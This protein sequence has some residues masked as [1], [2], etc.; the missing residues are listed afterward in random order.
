VNPDST[1]ASD[2]GDISSYDMPYAWGRPPS[3]YLAPRQVA[4]LTILRSRIR[5]RCLGCGAVA[6]H[7][8]TPEAP[9]ERRAILMCVRCGELEIR[10][11]RRV[12]AHREC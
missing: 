3:T 7:R 9:G 12:S 6:L 2:R 11:A 10:L 8:F 1:S 4:R 5:E